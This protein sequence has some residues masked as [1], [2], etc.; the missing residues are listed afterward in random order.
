MKK[1]TNKNSKIVLP[2][3]SFIPSKAQPENIFQNENPGG[4]ATFTPQKNLL[5]ITNSFITAQTKKHKTRDGENNSALAD[6]GI[7]ARMICDNM[8]SFS[9]REVLALSRHLD[10]QASALIPLV[11]LWIE[12]LKRHNRIKIQTS[13]YDWQ[14]YIFQ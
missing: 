4:L 14:E 5:E 6:F 9:E 11:H 1:Q 10:T 8:K 12:E 13:C 7:V 2:G 3:C